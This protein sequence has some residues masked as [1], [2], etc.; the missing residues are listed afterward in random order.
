MDFRELLPRLLAGEA[1]VRL[2]G[3]QRDPEL[4]RYMRSPAARPEVTATAKRI[5]GAAP[6][7]PPPLFPRAWRPMP[8]PAVQRENGRVVQRWSQTPQGGWALEPVAP[9]PT[10]LRVSPGDTSPRGHP[11]FAS[12]RNTT[13]PPALGRGA[14]F[15]AQ[16]GPE[17]P[18]PRGLEPADAPYPVPQARANWLVEDPA[19]TQLQ[20]E[21][22]EL[23]QRALE[24][25]RN[26]SR[27]PRPGD[28]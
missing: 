1:G 18:P 8:P 24:R 27:T 14:A 11:D 5:Q 17:Q 16:G 3:D 15:G 6:N 9:P 2:F 10:P 28:R 22:E 26:R 19:V 23:Y 7:Q 25:A 4:Q 21:E 20:A 12:W 13:H